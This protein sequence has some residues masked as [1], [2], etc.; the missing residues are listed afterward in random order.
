MKF[1]IGDPC[2]HPMFDEHD[3]WMDVLNVTDYFQNDGQVITFEDRQIAA[4]STKYGD[5]T[6]TSNNGYL[7][8]VDAGLISFVE[9]KEG[10]QPVEGMTL[11][12]F[13]GVPVITSDEQGTIRIAS[14]DKVL[15]I[16]TGADNEEDEDYWSSEEEDE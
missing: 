2:Y 9:W 16:Y 10:D 5:G 4:V 8:P 12:E 1:W 15:Y 13:G 11:I 14:A 7:F 3:V 6:Y